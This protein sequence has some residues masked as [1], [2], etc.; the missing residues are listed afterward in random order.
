MDYSIIDAVVVFCE[1]FKDDALVDQLIATANR[2]K[3]PVISV[4]E[5]R[6]NAVPLMFDYESGF[7]EILRHVVEEHGIHHTCMV[8]GFQGE[9]HSENRINIYKK[10][11]QENGLPF[12]DGQIYYGDYWWGPTKQA[13]QR[14]IVEETVP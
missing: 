6:Q 2:N 1:S 13:V 11:L 5:V 8:A 9:Y 12:S 10:V 3:T 14:M 4:G 7:E